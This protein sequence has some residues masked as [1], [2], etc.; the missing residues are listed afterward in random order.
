MTTPLKQTDKRWRNIRLG[1]SNATVG[2]YGC[3]TTALC[4]ALEKLRGYFCNPANAARYWAYNR[5]G[6]ILWNLTKFDGMKFVWRGYFFDLKKVK[7]YA[8]AAHLAVIIPVNYGAHWVYVDHVATNGDV[9][10]IDPINGKKY[11]KMPKIYTPCGYAIF[12]GAKRETPEWMKEAY[13]KAKKHGLDEH[14]PLTSVNVTKLQK[15]LFDMGII[16]KITPEPTIGWLCV[17]MEK[18]KERY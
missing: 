15:A 18:I 9:A 7:E 14:D 13:K 12:E 3:T 6:E 8:N 5:K 2:R 11:S 17:V 16:D 4:M 10:I 1:R